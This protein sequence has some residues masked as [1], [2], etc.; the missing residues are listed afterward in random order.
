MTIRGTTT[1]EWGQ[2]HGHNIVAADTVFA[3]DTDNTTS[4]GGTFPALSA[5]LHQ[6]P[7]PARP[8]PAQLRRQLRHRS[9]A[10][11]DGRSDHRVRAPTTTAR[12]RRRAR[13]SASTASSAGWATPRCRASRSAGVGDRRRPVHLQPDRGRDTDPRGLRRHRASTPGATG[14]QA[15]TRTCTPAATTSTRSTRASGSDVANVY[16]AYVKSGDLTGRRPRR[17]SRR[18]CRSPRTRATFATLQAHAKNNDTLPERP[19]QQRQGHLPVLPPG[20][21]QSAGRKRCGG[22]WKASSWSTTACT[23]APTPRRPF[24]SS[25]AAARCGDPGGLLRPSGDAVRELPARALQQVPREGL[26]SES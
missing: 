10:G 18:S 6:L 20:A 3:A 14:A 5:G 19:G 2:T 1:T 9:G 11:R 23:P 7:R 12:S 22:T 4:P 25:P 15:A 26:V 16:N 17:R 13:P 24:R 8:R 21:R